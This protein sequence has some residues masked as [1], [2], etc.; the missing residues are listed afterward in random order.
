MY[1]CIIIIYS[2]EVQWEYMQSHLSKTIPFAEL[3]FLI[4]INAISLW[5][6]NFSHIQNKWIYKAYEY[7]T[8][9][10][11][12]TNSLSNQED[13]RVV[14][15]LWQITFCNSCNLRCMYVYVYSMH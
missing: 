12:V 6:L 13:W 8:Q 15:N 5:I 7:I 11:Y 1:F 9:F 10:S 3:M 2:V 14:Y 4:L